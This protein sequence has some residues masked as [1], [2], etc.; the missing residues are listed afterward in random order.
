MVKAPVKIALAG[1]TGVIGRR[2][3]KHILVESETELA[4]IIDVDPAAPE[5]AKT[6]GVP[7]FNDLEEFTSARKAG[8]CV[9]EAIILATPTQTHVPLARKLLEHD[10]AILIEKPV[11]VTGQDG[12]ELIA[13][14][15]S[16]ENS[17]VMV[18][19][20]RRHN[21]YVRAIKK[22]VEGGKL[23]KIMAVNGVWTMRKSDEYFR[24]PWRQQAGAGGVVS[25]NE[26]DSL[27]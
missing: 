2:H 22:V 8:R 15:Q 25:V 6:H 16:H 23:G 26:H 3:L 19:H 4:A 20:H 5:L 9:A 18:G 11:A 12:R 10:I 13:A 17:V 27:T 21:C 14:C 24:V 7:L 1:A